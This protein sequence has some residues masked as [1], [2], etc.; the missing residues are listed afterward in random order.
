LNPEREKFLNLRTPP[1]RVVVE[2]AA[3][4]LGFASH[5]IPVLVSEGLLKPLGRPPTSG[6]KFFATAKL[7]ELRADVNW[8]AR[9]SD[10]I[11][12]H[13]QVRNARKKQNAFRSQLQTVEVA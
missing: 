5:D 11:V 8:L 3:W 13:W 4:I 12:K 9:A 1:A 2:E 7:Q 10:V 6:T